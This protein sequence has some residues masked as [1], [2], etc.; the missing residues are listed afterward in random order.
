MILNLAYLPTSK[1]IFL[2]NRQYRKSAYIFVMFEVRIQ[3]L[4]IRYIIN[5]PYNSLVFCPIKA[6]NTYHKSLIHYLWTIFA[7]WSLL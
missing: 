2:K 6:L 7:D 3:I 4:Q 1:H 5:L